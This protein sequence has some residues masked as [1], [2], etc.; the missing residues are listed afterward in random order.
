MG[1]LRHWIGADQIRPRRLDRLR[2]GLPHGLLFL[3]TEGNNLFNHPM[4][5]NYSTLVLGKKAEH[6][7]RS[8]AA[9]TVF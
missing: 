6:H 9:G 2:R 5:E 8:R 1:L 3:S 4:T 7:H